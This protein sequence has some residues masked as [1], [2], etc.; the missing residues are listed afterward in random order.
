MKGFTV[1]DVTFKNARKQSKVAEELGYNNLDNSDDLYSSEIP[2]VPIIERAIKYYRENAEGQYAV[3]YTATA[4][5]LEALLSIPKSKQQNA[6]SET[7]EEVNL[8][9]IEEEEQE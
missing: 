9:D 4:E 6:E 3:L 1:E 2:Q 8:N 7:V 5:W